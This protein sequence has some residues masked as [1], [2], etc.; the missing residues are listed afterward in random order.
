MRRRTKTLRKKKK[1][2][3]EVEK[4]QMMLEVGGF[5]KKMA[6]VDMMMGFLSL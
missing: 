4:H 5:T 3:K 1:K 2:R 6:S